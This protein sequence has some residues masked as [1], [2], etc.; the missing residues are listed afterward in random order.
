MNPDSSIQIYKNSQRAFVVGAL[1]FGLNAGV[2]VSQANA[3]IIR[4]NDIV[5]DGFQPVPPTGSPGIGIAH[6]EIDTDT[7]FVTINGEFSNLVGEVTFGHLH[8]IADFGEVGNLIFFPLTIEG[9]FMHSGTF[10]ATQRVSPFQLNVIL[11]SRS[12]INIHSSTNISGEIRGQIVVPST[13]ALST[14]AMAG[15]IGV[16]RPRR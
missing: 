9:D 2:L 13:G 7:R 5:L 6:V 16:R 1:C 10:H 12:Y 15:L 14:F 11:D 8:G 4:I 3:E